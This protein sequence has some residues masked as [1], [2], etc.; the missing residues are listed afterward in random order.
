MKGRF[1]NSGIRVSQSVAALAFQRDSRVPDKL[2]LIKAGIRPSVDADQSY[3][4]C[5][6]TP[7]NGTIGAL[8]FDRPARSLAAPTALPNRGSLAQP[9]AARGKG[10]DEDG[11]RTYEPS[12]ARYFFDGLVGGAVPRRDHSRVLPEVRR[13]FDAGVDVAILQSLIDVGI[14]GKRRLLNEVR[15]AAQPWAFKQE[16]VGAA[17]SSAATRGFLLVAKS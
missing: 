12:G 5:A 4:P 11:V 13:N 7:A 16:K 6:G 15:R 2:K 10:P 1:L 8:P 14:L 3:K 9:R 17:L